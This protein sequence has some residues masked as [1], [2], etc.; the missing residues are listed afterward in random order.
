M[1]TSLEFW[2]IAILSGISNILSWHFKVTAFRNDIVSRVSPISY[3]ESIFGLLIDA[4][5]FNTAFGILQLVGIGLVFLMF[6]I[7]IGHA[8]TIKV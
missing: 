8:M 3:L 2:S 6:L 5:V 1:P 7:K 4:F